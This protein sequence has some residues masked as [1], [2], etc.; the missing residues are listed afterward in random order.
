M[1]GISGNLLNYITKGVRAIG[2]I[3]VTQIKSK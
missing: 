3:I 2:H 1:T